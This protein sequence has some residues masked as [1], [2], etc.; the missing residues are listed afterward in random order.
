MYYWYRHDYREAARW[1]A[2]A[3]DL[4]GAPVWLKA[5]A[6][7]TLAQGGDRR[8][9][10][11]MWEALRQSAD[12]DWL[13]ANADFRLAQ[14]RALDDID[15]LQAIVDRFARSGAVVASWESLVR[16][17]A[18]RGI[19]VDPRGA[20]YELSSDNRVR[21]SRSS[22]LSPLPDEP[23]RAVGAPS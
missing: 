1:F 17:G 4:P 22:P 11:L 23:V 3:G 8:S 21:L 2:K 5:L 6:A 7:T 19:P 9:S 14:L 16:A 10:R 13:R 20:P 12:L 18:L 15:A